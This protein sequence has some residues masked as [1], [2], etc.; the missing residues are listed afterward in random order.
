MGVRPMNIQQV[1]DKGELWLLSANDSY[2]NHEFEIRPDVKLYFK[3]SK[4][5]DFLILT[6]TASIHYHQAKIKE[7]WK[8]VI[9]AWFTDG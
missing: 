6:G 3:G 9:K 7:L 4:H 1:D 5:A 2:S 8:P